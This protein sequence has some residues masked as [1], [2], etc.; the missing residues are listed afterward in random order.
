MVGVAEHWDGLPREG[1]E[2]PSL[3]ILKMQL[4]TALSNQL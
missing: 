1:G 4:N 3:E 2:S